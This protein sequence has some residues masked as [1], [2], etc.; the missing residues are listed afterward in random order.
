[1]ANI[2]LSGGPQLTTIV[3]RMITR[4]RRQGYRVAMDDVG[5]GYA[6]LQAIAEISPDYIKMDMSLVRDIHRH[7][8]KRELVS[9]IRRFSD[10]TGITLV[11]E[12][13][14]TLDELK[15]LMNTG[16][17]CAQGF[18]FSKPA[19]TPVEPDWDSIPKAT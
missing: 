19:R 2:A 9:T 15:S 4:C 8:I 11:A 13:V 14:E 3:R 6:G 10:S 17:R 1:M 18:L 12:G 5:S 7:T 16:V